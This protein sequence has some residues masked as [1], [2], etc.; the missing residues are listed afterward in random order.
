[1]HRLIFFETYHFS[2]RIKLS[3]LVSVIYVF[4]TR[5]FKVGFYEAFYSNVVYSSKQKD[6]KN[7]L[8]QL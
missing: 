6:Y 5:S 1:M 7:Q 4:E 8:N 2:S 3:T